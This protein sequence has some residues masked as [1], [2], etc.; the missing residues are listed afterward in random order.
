[1]ANQ[2]IG[3]GRGIS[4]V[5]GLG[6]AVAVLAA[7]CGGTD[8]GGGDE[9][10]GPVCGD[11]VAEG[12]EQCDGA[13]LGD[14]TCV[15]AGFDVGEIACTSECTIDVSAC[16][17]DE[18]QDGLNR[19]DEEAI[20]TDPTNPDTDSDGIPDGNEFAFGSDPLN[21]YSWPQGMGMWPNRLDEAQAAGVQATGWSVGQVPPNYQWVDQFG[22]VVDLHQFYGYGV[23]LSS[24]ATWCPPCNQA[25]VGAEELWAQ[26]RDNGI[27]FLE[28][29]AEGPT[30]GVPATA[31][32]VANW[33]N[34][35]ALSYPVMYSNSPIFTPSLPTFFIL[36]RELRVVQKIE[37]W[38]GDASINQAI[39]LIP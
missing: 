16:V 23:V 34:K 7:A 33:V 22:Q 13:D 18:D 3:W 27:I 12:N 14:A 25:A 15:T 19:F 20:G 37:G 17:T 2:G 6:L 30:Q 8:G 4:R 24:G 11:G 28:Q 32:D 1:M 9:P 35:Y 29:L 5:V 31:Q 39:A 36:D 21:P 10:E 38:G 26:H